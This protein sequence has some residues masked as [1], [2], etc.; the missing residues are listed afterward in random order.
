MQID[1]A[2]FNQLGSDKNSAHPLASLGQPP[3]TVNISKIPKV[4]R[5]RR[6]RK[7][8]RAYPT[9]PDV[10]LSKFEPHPIMSA[11]RFF[12]LHRIV[13]WIAVERAVAQMYHQL[14]NLARSNYVDRQRA[15]VMYG[16][17]LVKS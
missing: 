5:L 13:E 14:D 9:L 11:I 15:C 12:I 3:T 16:D 2:K 10:N 7:M 17:N 8:L 6:R 1:N 4:A